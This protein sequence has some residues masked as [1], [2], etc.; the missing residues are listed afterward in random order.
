MEIQYS[1]KSYKQLKKINKGDRKNCLKILWEIEQYANLK[2]KRYDIKVLKGKYGKFKR[3]R[4]GDYRV[5]FEECENIMRIYEI[6][7][8]QEAY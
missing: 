3:L 6:K 1:L 8:R 7:H 5:I 4:I 2:T